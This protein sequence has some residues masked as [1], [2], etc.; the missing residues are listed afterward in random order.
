MRAILLSTTDKDYA[1]Y[2]VALPQPCRVEL[3]TAP[4]RFS[5]TLYPVP[6][7]PIFISHIHTYG[8]RTVTGT[9][10][11][12]GNDFHSIH[13][14]V[15]VIPSREF[16]GSRFQRGRKASLT[17]TCRSGPYQSISSS[18]SSSSDSSSDTSSDTSSN[19]KL[20]KIL[21]HP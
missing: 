7:L 3:R 2:R 9:S 8:Y 15:R 4:C 14:H 18:S 17:R 12:C 10:T 1:G 6:V 19:R 5:R 20:C 16:H 21:C 13:F 11:L